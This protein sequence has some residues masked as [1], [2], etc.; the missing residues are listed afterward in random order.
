MEAYG[1]GGKEKGDT[2]RLKMRERERER[3][4]KSVSLAHSRGVRLL[5]DVE[6]VA[7]PSL[8]YIKRAQ[9]HTQQKMC[10]LY[11]D[12]SA[13]LRSVPFATT[14]AYMCCA[15]EILYEKHVSYGTRR[16]GNTIDIARETDASLSQ[17]LRQVRCG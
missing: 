14:P 4:K 12:S 11:R 3:V 15:C 10:C 8:E 6:E 5:D 16:Y 9:R 13:R 1:A 17:I 7:K 2:D